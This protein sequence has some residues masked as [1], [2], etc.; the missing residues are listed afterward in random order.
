MTFIAPVVLLTAWLGFIPSLPSAHLPTP[1]TVSDEDR[2]IW[3]EF[4]VL[5][6][7]GRIGEEH[8]R[9]AYVPNSTMLQFLGSMR[10]HASW[11]EWER[12]P[13]V[14][15]VGNLVHFV[16]RLSE[17]CVPNTYS[18]TFV[19]EN[20]RWVLQHFEGI[21]LRLDRLGE[22]PVTTFPDLGEDKKA[23]MRA[24]N[25]WSQMVYLFRLMRA[26]TGD[27]AAFKMF[28]DG[29]GYLVAARTWIPFVPPARAFVLYACWAQSRLHGDKVTLERLDDNQAVVALEPI[30]FALY[31]QTGHLRHQIAE[32]DYR[33]IFETIWSD[34]AGEAGW[35]AQFTYDGAKVTMRLAKGAPGS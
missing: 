34:R 12:Q 9:A 1:Q 31:R 10:A 3:P 6:K 11:P 5:M 7:E 28:R 21:V 23:W 33:R 18:F 19:S 29:A 25:Y 26:A 22:L 27:E 2:R 13:E 15:R 4:A 17:N 8:V 14:Y 30:Y 16:T 35:K 24:E 20:G 32:Q